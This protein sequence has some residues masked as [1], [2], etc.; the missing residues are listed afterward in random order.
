MSPH[1]MCMG[2]VHLFIGSI[3]YITLYEIIAIAL[4][5]IH[6]ATNTTRGSIVISSRSDN[7]CISGFL[8]RPLVTRF[9]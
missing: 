4:D 3:W 1:A 8:L 2:N 9:I 7:A 6:V 5:H